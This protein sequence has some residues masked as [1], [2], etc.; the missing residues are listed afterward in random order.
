MI[1]KCHYEAEKVAEVWRVEISMEKAQS[2]DMQMF[3]KVLSS[4]DIRVLSNFTTF[5]K[6]H[7]CACE[8]RTSIQHQGA[9]GLRLVLKAMAP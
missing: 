1:R 9:K 2:V 4:S 3:P 8:K 5:K 6:S 7:C